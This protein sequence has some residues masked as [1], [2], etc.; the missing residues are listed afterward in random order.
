[1]CSGGELY[2][3]KLNQLQVMLAAMCTPHSV[4]FKTNNEKKPQYYNYALK[5]CEHTY[6]FSNRKKRP[7]PVAKS[8]ILNEG[9]FI[10]SI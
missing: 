8:F 10:L 2:P 6:L 4:M 1:M 7:H 3:I 9:K 5:Y